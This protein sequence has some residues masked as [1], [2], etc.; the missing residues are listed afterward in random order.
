MTGEM[1][2]L[3][4]VRIKDVVV[5]RHHVD[6]DGSSRSRELS[7][8]VSLCN[9]RF[10]SFLGDPER[11]LRLDVQAYL[12]RGRASLTVIT[13]RLDR[14]GSLP[15]DQAREAIRSRLR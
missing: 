11:A 6:N 3:L 14:V 2:Q 10:N 8:L 15:L 1:D 13:F 12:Q 9:P 4:R 5:I 7:V